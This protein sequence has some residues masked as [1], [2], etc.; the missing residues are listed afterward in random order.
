LAVLSDPL[1]RPTAEANIP[2][3]IDVEPGVR[4][5]LIEVLCGGGAMKLERLVPEVT[6]H[7]PFEMRDTCRVVFHR[8]R[9]ST[10]YG[11]QKISFEIEVLRADGSPR[12]EAH[13]SE[14]M[15]FRAGSE[16]RFAFIS[17]IRDQFDRMIVRVSHVADE[18][19]YIGAAEIRTGAPA[20][21]WSAVIGSGRLRLY[22]TTTIPTGLYRFGDKEHSGVLSLNFGVLSRLTWLDQEGHEGFLGA[23]VGVMVIG[24]A[25]SVSQTGQSL[26]QVGLVFGLGVSVPVAN[27]SGPTQ[28]SISVHAWLELD[29]QHASSE[30]GSPLAFVFGPSLTFGN[31]GLNL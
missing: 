14:V 3:P 26:R 8:E 4:P 24:L 22:G 30:G 16:P 25:N 7:L 19:H 17:G 20:A 11:T 29:L 15:L 21:Q 5:P 23:E 10:E 9:L 2:A 27:R 13:V 18:N 12:G 31:V 6:A 1:Q 28:A